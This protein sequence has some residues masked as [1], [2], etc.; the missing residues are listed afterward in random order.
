MEV[1]NKKTPPFFACTIAQTLNPSFA[2]SFAF[3][4]FDYL[5]GSMEAHGKAYGQCIVYARLIPMFS[6]PE[7][8]EKILAFQT[9]IFIFR[10]A[11]SETACQPNTQSR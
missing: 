9:H 7:K 5:H 1:T 4:A 2:R 3:V 10:S 11:W 8:S 6:S